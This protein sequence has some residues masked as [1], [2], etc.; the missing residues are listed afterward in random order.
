MQYVLPLALK[1]YIHVIPVVMEKGFKELIFYYF[2]D[3]QYVDMSDTGAD[4]VQFS[5]TGRKK[6]DHGGRTP[7]GVAQMGEHLPC[8][9]GVRGSIPLI[10][11]GKKCGE[12]QGEGRR[13]SNRT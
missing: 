4:A 12:R 9:Q 5:V 3:I 13:H 10:S 7:G 8:K 1:Q 2:G 11:T 6:T